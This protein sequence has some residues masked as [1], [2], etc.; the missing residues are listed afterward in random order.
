MNIIKM[1]ETL[2]LS[3]II[4]KAVS[5]ILGVST[6]TL[7]NDYDDP[8]FTIKNINEDSI[9]PKDA[10]ML[11]KTISILSDVSLDYFVS[12]CEQDYQNM[13]LEIDISEEEL[14]KEIN[15]E[16]Y[17]SL[18]NNLRGELDDLIEN[19]LIK[20]GINIHEK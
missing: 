13:L 3:Y 6:L 11:I 1:Q 14:L 8:N 18:T 10:I 12:L 19:S 2:D 5:K 17:Y 9:S 4:V 16:I 7:I 15:T 20:Y